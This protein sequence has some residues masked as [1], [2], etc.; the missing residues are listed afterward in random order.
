[1]CGVARAGRD[2]S[3]RWWHEGIAKGL[4]IDVIDV[5]RESIHAIGDCA[6][7]IRGEIEARGG[8][9]LL[10]LVLLWL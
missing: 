8:G 10:R 4:W 2:G 5:R 9:V 1:M 6:C 3:R 7:G